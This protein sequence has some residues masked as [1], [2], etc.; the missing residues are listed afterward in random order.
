MQR[1]GNP[2]F[3][4]GKDKLGRNAWLKISADKSSKSGKTK[5]GTSKGSGLRAVAQP[6]NAGGTTTSYMPTVPEER[7]VYR[8]EATVKSVRRCR[9]LDAEER[10]LLEARFGMRDKGP[11]T[12]E[13]VASKFGVSRAEIRQA[14]TLA[15]QKVRAADPELDAMYK[16]GWINEHA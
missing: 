4:L 8:R 5:K 10:Q 7:A 16:P 3:R 9:S 13:E 2:N 6:E 14:E 15:L 12:L 1:A 11:K